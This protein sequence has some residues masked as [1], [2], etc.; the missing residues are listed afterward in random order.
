MLELFFIISH[1]S[2]LVAHVE[3]LSEVV[4]AERKE[5]GSERTVLNV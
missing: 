4:A 3:N 2:N 1:F 5:L